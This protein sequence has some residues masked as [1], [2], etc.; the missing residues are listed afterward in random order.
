MGRLGMGELFIIF[1]MILLVVGPTKLPALAK[2]MGQALKEFKKGS[3]DVT[4][5]LEEL[6]TEPVSTVSAKEVKTSVEKTILQEE[7]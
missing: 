5:K 2:S 3:Q 6:A 4:S 7:A 1:A